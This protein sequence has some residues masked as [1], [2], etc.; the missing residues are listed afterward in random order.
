MTSYETISAASV[1]LRRGEVSSVS[2]TETALKRADTHDERLG[3]FVTR[4]R[5]AALSAA[6][7][8]DEDFRS[9]RDRGPLQGI[10]LG[11]KDIVSTS[12]GPTSAQSLVLDPA[13]GDGQ[14][15][16]PVVTRLRGSGGVIVGKTTTSEFAIG[17][18]DPSK[19]FPIPRNPWDLSRWPGGSSSGTA[20]GVSAGFF[21]G[22]LG[23][24]SGGSIRLP[25]A[26]SGVT[27]LKPT[28]GRVPKAGVVPLGYSFDTVGPL[29]RS[30]RDVALLLRAI[31]GSDPAD[32]TAD[33]RAV[34][35]YVAALTGDLS[36]LRIGVDRLAR[37]A[38]EG[39][40]DA[41]ASLLEA[42]L[43]ALE[44]AG[45][46]LVEV[47]L[48]F[49]AE[50][51]TATYAGF[52][53]EALA[54]HTPDLRSRWSE[55][56]PST[57]TTIARSAFLT[58]SDYVQ[59][60]RVRRVGQRALAQV[61][62]DVDLLATPTTSV[63]AVTFESLEDPERLWHSLLSRVHTGV[64]NAV[65]NPAIAVPIGFNAEGLPLSLQLAG[66]PFDESLVLR[67]ADAYQQRTSWHLRQP[68]IPDPSV[69]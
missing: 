12:E 17:L 33:A 28:Y 18:P 22:G 34:P 24:D 39:A 20:S 29:A 51:T 21:L 16:A 31:A 9:G 53:S 23:T 57:R 68:A 37:V 14:G 5:D 56:G 46:V 30:A 11:I 49:Y 7:R 27:G 65:G 48:P 69:S 66:R 52:N 54:H 25:S 15:D 3:V 1:A 64:W 36:G 47:T 19:P 45:A 13:W 67:A 55:Y 32:P 63:A 40:D 43:V 26:F 10:P 44:E 61:F 42:A 58:A 4:Y 35:D 60:Q 62:K 8:A 6:S 38:G 59:I 50:L 41:L 2:L